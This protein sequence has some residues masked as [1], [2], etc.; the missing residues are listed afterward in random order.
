MEILLEA[1]VELP[2]EQAG[3]RLAHA[4]HVDVHLLCGSHPD[5]AQ[6]VAVERPI[7]VAHPWK[8]VVE[9]ADELLEVRAI[10]ERDDGARDVAGGKRRRLDELILRE[11]IDLFGEPRVLARDGIEHRT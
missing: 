1:L 5:A 8:R 4:E 7:A 10:L 3:R 6:V 9:P 2:F 11:Q